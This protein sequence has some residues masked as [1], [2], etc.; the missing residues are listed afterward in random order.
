MDE[1]LGLEKIPEW[2]KRAKLRKMKKWS[3]GD[4]AGP[5]N[6][7][8][9]VTDKCNL[10]CVHCD[11]KATI[12]DSET[13]R[14][15]REELSKEE[16]LSV[17]DRANEMNIKQVIIVGGGEPFC[18]SEKVMEVMKRI[19]EYNMEGVIVTNGTLITKE[20]CRKLVEINWNLLCFSLDG[21]NAKVN[22]ELR[23]EN[24]FGKAVKNILRINYFKEQM[25][26]DQPKI[27]IMSVVTNRIHDKM[28][29]MIE[30]ANYLDSNEV[31]LL[32]LTVHNEKNKWLKPNQEELEH[33]KNNIDNNMALA[34]NYGIKINLDIFKDERVV[35]ESENMENMI[36]ENKGQFE[37][38]I[39]SAYCYK[40][41][42]SLCV[43][44]KGIVSQCMTFDNPKNPVLTETDSN[45]I[46]LWYNND[47]FNE[48]RQK[49]IEGD[50]PQFCSGCCAPWVIEEKLIKRY[51]ESN[52]EE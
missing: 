2:E 22:D 28:G 13:Y 34:S 38:D 11:F 26:E 51:L 24:V 44:A 12:E 20:M 27:Q 8:L 48:I 47:W 21:P 9:A 42:L 39:L 6:L 23:G 35:E 14:E 50:L 43:S 30:L 25:N 49:L 41:W 1:N 32:N 33:L 45:L 16:L 52:I 4:H 7:K 40:P 5:F 37:S 18:A 15:D 10:N 46:D 19:K 17:V 3:E 31:K 36:R 29:E